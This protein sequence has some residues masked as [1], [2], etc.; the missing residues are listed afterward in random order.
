MSR[1]FSSVWLR[2][3]SYLLLFLK[4]Y[5]HI[6]KV[7][8]LVIKFQKFTS[9]VRMFW[10][11]ELINWEWE[12]LFSIFRLNF[13]EEIVFLFIV[14]RR[15]LCRCSKSLSFMETASFFF[16][17]LAQL[18]LHLYIISII[19]LRPC[20]LNTTFSLQELRRDR[21][22]E[23]S[24]LFFYCQLMCAWLSF[25]LLPNN[26]FLFLLFDSFFVRSL[27]FDSTWTFGFID[28]NLWLRCLGFGWFGFSLE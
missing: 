1:F 25:Y 20:C 3:V 10:G 9:F 13:I 17:K 28:G 26:S 4:S 5:I 15:E 6:S 2:L 21:L 12:L 23:L 7:L 22:W 14:R 27:E 11:W 19:A 8:L 24:L 18:P 16:V